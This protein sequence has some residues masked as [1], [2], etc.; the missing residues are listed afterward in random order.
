MSSQLLIRKTHNT[1]KEIL[2]YVEYT[3]TETKAM[4]RK[5]YKKLK[6]KKPKGKKPHGGDKR[7]EF[8]EEY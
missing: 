8:G 5:E 6:N 4:Q 7:V 2:N 1:S 3:N